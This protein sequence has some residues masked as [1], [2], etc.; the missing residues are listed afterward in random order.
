MRRLITTAAAIVLATV[1]VP[2]ALAATATPFG[3]ATTSGGILT[4]RVEHG[5]RRRDERLLRRVVRGNG[6]D[7]VREHHDAL[8][9]VQRHGRRLRRRVSAVPGP[10]PDAR[11]REE[12][13]RLSRPDAVVHRMLAERLDR[14][15]EPDR[16]TRTA[17]TTRARCRPGRRCRRYA[18][19]LA[20]VGSYQVTGI[21]LV[22]DSGW[23][24]RRQGAD[25]ARFA[26]SR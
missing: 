3:G 14:L 16:L 12:R 5:R 6:R 2:A 13:V 18:Q 20:L 21:S 24:L 22:V 23:A 9:R 25:G 15:R 19:A 1:I 10:R 26:T 4:P 7:D 8:D 11:G 17:G